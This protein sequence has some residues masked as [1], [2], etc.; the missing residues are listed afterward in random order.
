RS[1]KIARSLADHAIEK[2]P[3]EATGHLVA[4][5]VAM[6]EKDLERAMA[7][8]EFVL[9]L[10]PNNAFAYSSLGNVEMYYGRALAAIPHLEKAMQLD[11][12][13]AQQHLHFLGTAYLIA[14]RFE[15]A[16]VVLKQRVLLVPDTDL[17]RALLAAALG[18]LGEA[19]KARQT[20][21]EL[22][23]INP[24]YS[25]EEH[26]GRLPFKVPAD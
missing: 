21:Q 18:H 6:F 11:P 17:S 8:T 5:R 22:K 10:E 7:E 19:E 26:V 1:L 2:G 13:F 4:A 3:N 14:G 20:W 23:K 9:S 12:A 16:A 24:K 25:F 15:T